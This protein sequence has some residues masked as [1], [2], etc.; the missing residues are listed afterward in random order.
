MESRLALK[1]FDIFDNIFSSKSSDNEDV[2]ALKL[3]FWMTFSACIALFG[4]FV[5]DLFI[6]RYHTAMILIS[7]TIVVLIC[8]YV[9]ERKASPNLIYNISNVIFFVLFLYLI[10]TSQDIPERLLWSYTF[11]IATIAVRGL[12][13]GLI[14]SLAFIVAAVGQIF[15]FLSDTYS[16]LFLATFIIIYLII[17]LIVYWIEFYKN[18]FYTELKSQN[19]KLKKEISRRMELEGKLIKMSQIDS[20][21]NLLN[22]KFFWSYV[23]REIDKSKRYNASVFMA[24]IDIDNFKQI[25]DTFGH[26]VGDSVIKTIVGIIHEQT[27]KTDIAGRIGGDEFAILLL[28]IDEKT[29][30]EKMEKLRSTIYKTSVESIEDK[31]M[32]ISVGM[33]KYTTD[34][35]DSEALFKKADIALYRAKANGRNQI[36]IQKN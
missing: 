9:I 36:M 3:Y 34:L 19:I 16:S 22:Q 15:F 2:L 13:I 20:L 10:H 23:Q 24:I 17:V 27:R 35:E 32:S 6:G 12:K 7:A 4:F 11:P 26:L 8:I 29:A 25:N 21:T 5:Y 33:A 30:Y 14:W 18:R 28:N 31:K 1:F